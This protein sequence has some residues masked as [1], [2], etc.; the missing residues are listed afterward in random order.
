MVFTIL[1]PKEK[2]VKQVMN[3]FTTC[4]TV[5]IYEIGRKQAKKDIFQDMVKY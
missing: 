2:E 4:G 5:S 1:F 3:R